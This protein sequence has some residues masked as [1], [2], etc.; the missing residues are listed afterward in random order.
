MRAVAFTVFEMDINEL[1]LFPALQRQNR[2][3][4]FGIQL[5]PCRWLFADVFDRTLGISRLLLVIISSL[6]L[7]DIT[8]THAENVPL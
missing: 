8:A 5:S 6:S 2:T 4:T 3:E 7:V 1:G